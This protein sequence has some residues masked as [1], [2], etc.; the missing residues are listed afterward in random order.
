M[1]KVDR[2]IKNS[3][4]PILSI[5]ITPPS[6][7]EK[8]DKLLHSIES[9]VP[10]NLKFVNITTHQ[11]S[12]EY[13]E[14]GDEI[15]KIFRTKK[16][17]TIGMSNKIN[18]LFGVETIPHI[19]VGGN[20]KH[21]LEDQLID[22][23]YLGFKRVFVV[24]GDPAS[25]QKRFSSHPDGYLYATDLVK[26]ITN[27]NKGILVDGSLSEVA[28]EF[29]IGVASY[30]EKHIESLNR[31][32][33]FGHLREKIDAGASYTITQMGFSVE[34]LVEFRDML[35]RDIPIVPG[36]KPITSLRQMQMIPRTFFVDIPP[37]FVREMENA[38][39]RADEIECGVNFSVNYIEKLLDNGFHGAHIFTMGRGKTTKKILERLKGAFND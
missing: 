26:Q 34:K 15:T 37:S 38:K 16:P 9:L 18:R 2:E 5:E 27:L 4:R 24:R 23:H 17:G 21:Q 39:T 1:T 29:S 10:Y 31:E 35:Q 13:V 25:G 32:S 33:D 28:T 19:I 22:L 8:Y 36:I 12:V 14:N 20:S 11:P 3:K 30:P 6:R 7:G